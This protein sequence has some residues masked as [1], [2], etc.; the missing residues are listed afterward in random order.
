MTLLSFSVAEMHALLNPEV[1]KVLLCDLCPIIN[2][3][4]FSHVVCSEDLESLQHSLM[5]N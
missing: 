5:T 3:V 1:I 4:S 2:W